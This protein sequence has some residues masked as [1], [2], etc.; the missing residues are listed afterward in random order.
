[1]KITVYST[2]ICPNCKMLKELLAS[3]N[4]PFQEIDMGT[5]AALTELSV[6][7][8][9]TRMAPVLQIDNAFYYKEIV[10]VGKLNVSMVSDIL[11]S[12]KLIT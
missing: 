5:P 9:F 7:G 6:N 10:N 1:M 4:I 11:K 8:V 3:K 2:Q 12:H